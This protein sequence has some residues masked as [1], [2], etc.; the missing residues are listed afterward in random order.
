MS[1]RTSQ[2]RG[3]TYPSVLEQLNST[4]EDMASDSDDSETDTR[5]G[6]R[7]KEATKAPEEESQPFVPETQVVD[8]D[9]ELFENVDPKEEEEEE[10]VPPTAEPFVLPS[11]PAEAGAETEVEVK[12]FAEPSELDVAYGLHNHELHF[13]RIDPTSARLVV[14]QKKKKDGADDSTASE[15]KAPAAAAGKGSGDKKEKVPLPNIV[16]GD[17]KTP[18]FTFL[19]QQGRCEWDTD[20]IKGN[21]DPVGDG[22]FK[23]SALDAIRISVPLM[24]EVD[25]PFI[26][27][28]KQVA[29]TA[30]HK[31]IDER[32]P[33]MRHLTDPHYEAA[34]ENTTRSLAKYNPS[35]E[36][37]QQSIMQDYIG[38]CRAEFM[39]ACHEK[40]DKKFGY[41]ASITGVTM[42]SGK[43]T[44]NAKKYIKKKYSD[45]PVWPIEFMKTCYENNATYVAGELKVFQNLPVA[46]PSAPPAAMEI[47]LSADTE[48]L[49]CIRGGSN[50]ALQVQ[51]RIVPNPETRKLCF[52]YRLKA[53][54]KCGKEDNGGNGSSR[55]GGQYSDPS[56]GF[57]VVPFDPKLLA[58]MC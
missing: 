16:L 51:M 7:Y 8:D 19:T 5:G 37:L 46:K 31:I 42:G 41:G 58:E 45:P 10:E 20:L 11:A 6:K 24:Y 21:Y 44:D 15:A 22:K 36:D 56:G 13:S 55:I 49:R 25:S 30:L 26:N 48:T 27:W 17:E 57:E 53:V 52:S 35:P 39:D 40:D 4:P 29:E 18:I 38:R 9:E 34:V 47:K 43:L 1:T 23:T 12:R 28:I 33:S 2:K 32:D 14:L 50:V 3:R 54:H